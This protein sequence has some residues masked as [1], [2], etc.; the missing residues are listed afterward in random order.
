MLPGTK[1]LFPTD[2]EKFKKA[3]LSAAENDELPVVLQLGDVKDFTL[4]DF[5]DTFNDFQRETGLEVTGSMF[6]CDH[7]DRL[8]LNLEFSLPAMNEMIPL[9]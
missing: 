3:M 6:L 7:C 4:K 9:Q 1:K 5:Q 8:H 2:Y